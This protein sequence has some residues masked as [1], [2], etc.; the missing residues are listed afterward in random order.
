MKSLAVLVLVG[1]IVGCGGAKTSAP[2]SGNPVSP[3]ATVSKGEVSGTVK[4]NGKPL[5]TGSILFVPASGEGPTAES[6]IRD[7]RYSVHATTG[8]MK[9]SIRAPKVVG[10][11]KIYPTPDS[12]EMPVTKEE[13]PS[14]YNDKTELKFDVRHGANQ[15]DFDLQK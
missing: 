3:Q 10:K 14:K 11:K 2:P 6:P 15:K 8:A 12:P 13:L 5:E 4:V 7:G 9:V 1:C